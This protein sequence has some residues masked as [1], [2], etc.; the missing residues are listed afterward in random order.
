MEIWKAIPD[1]NGMIEVSD[2]GRVRSWLSGTPRVLKAT[3]DAKGYLKIMLT[4]NRRKWGIRVHREVA[5]A[6][7]DN[8]NNLPQV[9][10]IDGNKANNSVENLEWVTN[11]ENA[12]HA[13]RNGLWDSVFKGALAEN[14][15]RKKPILATRLDD[16]TVIYFGSVADAERAIGS[17]HIT[18]VLKGKRKQ[19]KGFTFE[20]A[21]GV[22]PCS[23]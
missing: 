11:K 4:V 22:M 5:K 9:N 3:P 16:G 8:P 14:E 18:D 17:R 7:I 15:R 1:T 13:I 6:F 20:Y 23:L 12:A 19:C 10:H 2:C 21:K